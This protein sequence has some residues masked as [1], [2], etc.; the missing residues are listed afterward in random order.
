MNNNRL[1]A[2]RIGFTPPL[3]SSTPSMTTLALSAAATW[4]GYTFIPQSAKT[5]ANVR[6]Y[7]SAVSGTLAASDITCSLYQTAN[8]NL[9]GL[10]LLETQPCAAAPAAAGWYDWTD[11]T[12]ALTAGLQ[13]LLVFKN[14]NASPGSNFPTFQ[15]ASSYTGTDPI[16][17]GTAG[18]GSGDGWLK[19]HSTNSGTSWGTVVPSTGGWRVGYSD[20]SYDGLPISAAATSVDKVYGANESGVKF[21][22]PSNAPLNVIGIAFAGDESGPPSF[23]PEFKL[24]NGADAAVVT[25]SLGLQF[26]LR[27]GWAAGYLTSPKQLTPGATIRATIHAV[28][29]AG[30]AFNY[31]VANEYTMDPD[32]NSLTLLPFAGTL[33]K[34]YWNGSTWT[35]TPG[36]IFPFALILDVQGEFGA[37]SGGAS[38]GFVVGG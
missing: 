34:T 13:F 29:N 12:T 3:L 26:A 11:F 18:Q 38:R 21:T 1:C 30:G 20:G 16:L 6:A 32:V 33:S 24:Y 31:Y 23:A 19:S 4:L 22:A 15:Y 35:D 36:S 27:G 14:A 25:A 37:Q 5:L 17:S 28:G 9:G 10:T 7:L 2:Q 8:S